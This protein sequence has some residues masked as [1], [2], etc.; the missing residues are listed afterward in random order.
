MVWGALAEAPRSALCDV[1]RDVPWF[2]AFDP[3]ASLSQCL[4]GSSDL[5][6]WVGK[7]L[8]LEDLDLQFAV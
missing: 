4:W 1:G 2:L 6:M 3:L 5:Q 8:V 7:D